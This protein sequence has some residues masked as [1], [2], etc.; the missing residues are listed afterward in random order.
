MNSDT[1]LSIFLE[2]K[3]KSKILNI[4]LFFILLIIPSFPFESIQAQIK[5]F[6][7]NNNE[8]NNDETIFKSETR[9]KI[10]LGGKWNIAFDNSEV[11]TNINVPFATDY[12][13]SLVLN[14]SFDI[15]DSLLSKYNFI[16][17]AFWMLSI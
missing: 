5:V 3:S 10:D 1:K 17:Y 16:F 15:N 12:R 9:I 11:Y 4:F 14:R 7:R 8:L 2:F 6:E 13:N